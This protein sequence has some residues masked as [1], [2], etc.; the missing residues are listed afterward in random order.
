M[1][2]LP[3]SPALDAGD[4]A[5]ALP[6]DQRGVPR[7]YGV[8]SDVGAYECGPPILAALPPSQTTEVGSSVHLSVGTL[9]DPA[10]SYLWFFNGA[11]LIHGGTNPVLRLADV[12][13]SQAGIY[14]I[15]VANEF[16]AAT[17]PPVALSVIAPVERTTVRAI[18]LAGPPEEDVSL[19]YRN[20]L[21]AEI[22]WETLATTTLGNAAQAYIDPTTP[23]PLQRFYRAWRATAA[24]EAPRLGL[25]L[26]PA[27][28]LTGNEGDSLRLDCLQ[29]I[30][31][32]DAWVTLDTVTLT[33]ATQFYYD[34]SSIGQ[35]R[36]LYRIVPLR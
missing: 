17:S 18:R 30:G 34:V 23:V 26:V 11:E 27:I 25:G 1:A 16:G 29:A 2:L 14:S 12:Q 15:V 8:S 7:S 6:T 33:N 24:G 10:T 31:P 4:D 9:G 13:M 35:P 36:R 21:G 5:A 22:H 20:S 28:T 19:D 32:T 3:G